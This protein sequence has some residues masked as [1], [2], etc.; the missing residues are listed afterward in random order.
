M[1]ARFD[2]QQLRLGD[3]TDASL[4][5]DDFFQLT[6]T[7]PPYNVGLSYGEDV[8]DAGS[9]EQYLDF[10][11]RWL[12]N[13][14]RWSDSSGRLCMNIPLDKNSGGKQAVT[15]DLTNIARDVGW[16]YHATII[17]NEGNISRRTA[18]GSWMRPSAPHVI[19]PV[20]TIVVLYKQQWNRPHLGDER[21]T[22]ERDEFM[23]WTSGVW[24]APE[25]GSPSESADDAII[26][27]SLLMDW[28][29]SFGGA[30]PVKVSELRHS[31]AELL[32]RPRGPGLE[33]LPSDEARE[34][35]S[36]VWTF[37]GESAKRIG[38]PAPFPIELPR[39]C[40]R[41]FSYQGDR[42]FDPFT[43]SGSTLVAA[44]RDEREA[45]GSE[46]DEAYRELALGRINAEVPRF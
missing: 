23:E 45:Y 6:V 37:G 19:A 44:S 40:I 32:T 5:P 8:D 13:V 4:F 11:R 12:A 10:S 34:W 33:G 28:A 2:P 20:E 14:Y 42:V 27:P 21:V 46:I 15:A 24:T 35:A 17:W 3:A 39:R 43:G 1:S 36:Q 16:Q 38:H 22:I 18:W 31:F 9:Y 25:E 26:A 30:S 41:L 29:M 7:S